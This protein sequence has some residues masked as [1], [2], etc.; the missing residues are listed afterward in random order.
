[1]MADGTSYEGEFNNDNFHG[2]VRGFNNLRESLSGQKL[3]IMREI[4]R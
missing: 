2:Y 1:M 4:G 3:D